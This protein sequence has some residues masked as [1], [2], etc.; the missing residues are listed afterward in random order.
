MCKNPIIKKN[1][2]FSKKF[3]SNTTN[4]NEEK[5][6]FIKYWKKSQNKHR[7]NL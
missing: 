4:R 3:E 1:E 2:I 7:M 6:K 5:K